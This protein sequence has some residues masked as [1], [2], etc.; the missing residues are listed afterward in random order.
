[1]TPREITQADLDYWADQSPRIVV[2]AA[3]DPDTSPC[4]AV[5]TE[6]NDP[7][8]VV[9]QTVVRVPWALNE[10]EMMHLVKGGTLWLSTWGGLPPHM[11]EVQAPAHE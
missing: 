1:M 10:I 6:T 9:G 5:V 4:P 11:I 7:Y 2:F 3:D 8:G